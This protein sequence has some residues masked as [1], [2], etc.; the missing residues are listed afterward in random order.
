MLPCGIGHALRE[1][2]TASLERRPGAKSLGDLHRRTATLKAG[3]V[4]SKPQSEPTLVRTVTEGNTA[5]TGTLDPPDAD[6]TP[7]LG[8][9]IRGCRIV[10]RSQGFFMTLS[11]RQLRHSEISGTSMRAVCNG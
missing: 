7:G 1:K 3:R 2:F 9:S 8:I 5:K 11:I 6:L 10:R 4:F